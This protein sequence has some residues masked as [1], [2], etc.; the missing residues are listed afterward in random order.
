MYLM[1]TVA[2]SEQRAPAPSAAFIRFADATP[3]PLIYTSVVVLGELRRGAARHRDERQRRSLAEWIDTVL[4]PSFG[5][6]VLPITEP[7]A[8]LW[9]ELMGDAIRRGQPVP[10]IDSFI[11]ATALVHGLI[12]VTRNEADFRRCG[13]AVRNPWTE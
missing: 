1:D 3:Q 13:V 10:T 9:G 4:R 2:C 5:E 12:V 8:N 6:R 7:I 11:A